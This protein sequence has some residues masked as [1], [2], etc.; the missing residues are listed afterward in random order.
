MVEASRLFD[1]SRRKIQTEH[2]CVCIAKIA[3]NV[4][5]T[6]SHLAY[7]AS[8]LDLGGETIEHFAV[9][10]L[11][12]KLI[13]KMARILVCEP[14]VILSDCLRDRLDHI[15]LVACWP[16]LNTVHGPAFMSRRTGFSHA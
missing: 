16:D 11:L 13:G 1:H 15:Y 2:I 5:G 10:R 6:T 8:G 9:E 12:C 7:L 4:A 14:V 3:R